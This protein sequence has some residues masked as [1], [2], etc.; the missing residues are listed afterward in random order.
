MRFKKDSAQPGDLSKIIRYYIKP[1]IDEKSVVAEIG[2][3]G[4]RWD[5]ALSKAKQLFLVELHSE[6]FPI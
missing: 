6:L 5:D 4:G 3:G 2:S 1:Y